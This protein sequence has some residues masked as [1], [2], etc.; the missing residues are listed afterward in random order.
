M[1][2]WLEFVWRAILIVPA[3]VAIALVIGK[4]SIG[5]LRV[6]DF[7]FVAVLAAMAA[8]ALTSL[9]ILF[10]G[11]IIAMA[12]LTGAYWL[13]LR[14]ALTVR[15][16]RLDLAGLLLPAYLRKGELRPADKRDR[17]SGNQVTSQGAKQLRSNGAGD[18]DQKDV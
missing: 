15:G 13:L 16:R 6:L 8:A 12:V 5:E 7:L 3:L 2:V 17:S 18:A 9:D 1:L 4:R 14:A 11:T 10:L